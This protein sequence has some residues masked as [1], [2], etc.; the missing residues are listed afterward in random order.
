MAQLLDGITVKLAGVDYVAP[1]MNLL[2]LKKYSPQLGAIMSGN[3]VESLENIGAVVDVVHACLVRNYPDL[4]V[5]KVS[6]I[7]DI[8]NMK[9]ALNAIMN[10]S[11]IEEAGK[12]KAAQ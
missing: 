8:K 5:E 10:V 9:D 11:G 12:A 1:P 2:T 4:T 7:L 3:G 6:E